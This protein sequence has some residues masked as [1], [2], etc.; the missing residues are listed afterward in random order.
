MKGYDFKKNIFYLSAELGVPFGIFLSIESM[1]SLYS[2]KVPFLG[3][4]SLLVLLCAPVILYFLQR[5]RFV[6]FNGF[7]TFSDLWTLAIFTSLGGSLIMAF[8]TYM[9]ITFMRPNVIYDQMQYILDNFTSIDK[10]MAKTL[11]KM[12][13]KGALPSPMDFSMMKFWFIASLGCVGG[14][15]TALIASKI[16]MK[17]VNA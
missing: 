6:A 17:K 2:D 9:T 7:S 16:P 3:N 4:I 11:K 14:A 15:I 12:V 10:D 5:K 13:D 8:T 1:A